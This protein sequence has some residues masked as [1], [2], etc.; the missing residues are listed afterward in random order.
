MWAVR[1]LAQDP[2]YFTV[3]GGDGKARLWSHKDT[4]TGPISTVSMSKHPVISCDWNRDKKG[5]LA[6]CSFDQT[7]KVSYLDGI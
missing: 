6:C 5:L 4:K 7:V 2:N 1:H 3:L